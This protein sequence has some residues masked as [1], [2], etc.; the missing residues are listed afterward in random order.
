MSDEPGAILV[1]EI[2]SITTRVMLFDVVDGETRLICQVERP[3][4]IEPPHEDSTIAILEGIE[5][6]SG[7]IGRTLL[8]ESGQLIMPQNEERD[9]VNHIVAVT[10]GAGNLGVI[11]TAIATDISA[12]S[13]LHA[14]RSTYSCIM[15]VVALDDFD[16]NR[17]R[18]NNRPLPAA[19][20][21][22]LLTT[23]SWIERQVE[24]MLAST[25]DVVVI[26]GGL[27][28]GTSDIPKRLAHIVSLTTLRTSVDASGQQRQDSIRHPV[29]YAGTSAAQDKVRDIL[30][31]RADVIV[32]DNVRPTL[33]RQ[34]LD[35]IRQEMDRL[36][37][38]HI[39]SRLP[40][41]E[42]LQS[43]SQV[44]ITTVY[45]A[46]NIVTRFV[47]ERY[48]RQVLTLD[49]GSTSSSAFYAGSDAYGYTVLGESGTGYGVMN[50]VNER[51]L[52]HIARWLP[53]VMNGKDLMHW[54][55]NKMFRPQ[56][57][58]ASLTDVLIEQAIAREA[59]S[60]LMDTV[61]DENPNLS[62]DI[63]L[64]CG[65]VLAHAPSPGMAVLM[66]LDALQPTAQQS[67][68]ALDIY[69]DT[70][71]LIPACGALA[72]LETDAAVTVFDRD[73]LQNAP[74]ATCIIALGDGRIGKIALEAELIPV[75]GEPKKVSVRH[76]EITYLPLYPGN[77]AQIIIR[78][79]AGVRIGNN[80]PGAEVKSNIAAINGSHMGVVIDARGRPLAIPGDNKRRRAQLWEWLAAI[81]AVEGPSPYLDAE[82]AAHGKKEKKVVDDEPDLPPEALQPVA[83][84]SAQPEQTTQD[85]PA[86]AGKSK[87]QLAQEAKQKARAEK[88]A[89]KEQARLHKDQARS[90]R[91]KGK[92]KGA[93]APDATQQP[94]GQ[95]D[96][97][98][99]VEDGA[100]KP[101]SRIS[102]ADLDLS[103]TSSQ[104][105]QASAPDPGSVESDL[106]SLRET[107][108]D[109]KKEKKDNKKGKAAGK[110]KKGGGIFGKR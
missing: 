52:A 59:L 27:E 60:L 56:L 69:L 95:S 100:L 20:K 68:L 6:I 49:I 63:I 107:V 89:A 17:E 64:A 94:A 77:K 18:L 28:G 72:R 14:C 80:P 41:I 10:S 93:P 91:K 51:G 110:K 74:L 99:V 76:G 3:S 29:I 62:Y 26:A 57:I 58:P 104:T 45:N 82:P 75:H 84:V 7:L 23:T 46:E 12:R 101:G 78:P 24:S 88:Q 40:G 83:A 1:A 92:G 102:L 54:I 39:L 33:E 42:V 36:Y 44:P 108:V 8:H 31:G 71:G 105:P 9:G 32:L 5:Q 87:R 53:F 61:A 37:H 16:K 43:L 50:I 13:S 22:A 98:A 73:I 90:E 38:E 21:K 15:Q 103:D 11:I 66:L 109:P 48:R 97:R 55:L 67:T 35:P 85:E 30:A 25:P 47:A 65:G 19:S 79:S 106:A 2:G 70:L 81:G 96:V 34:N 86:S 4:S